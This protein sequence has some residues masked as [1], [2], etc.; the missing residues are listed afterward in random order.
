MRVSPADDIDR[1]NY[2]D[3]KKQVAK[4]EKNLKKSAKAPWLCSAPWYSWCMKFSV[5]GSSKS[6]G[7]H[8]ERTVATAL[9]RFPE[10]TAVAT[11]GAY[12]V[13]TIAIQLL[14][15]ILPNAERP[16][17]APKGK[18][19]NRGVVSLATELIEVPGGYLKRDDKLAEFGE[20]GL[21]A[22]PL[23]P[24]EEMRSG[25]W[26]TIRRAK[27]LGHVVYLFPLSGG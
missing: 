15:R 13:D 17:Y 16:L 25:T 5:T 4:A 12:G 6:F 23:T 26:A 8:V 21:I 24:Y 14:P 22:F 9:S 27:K 2:K 3:R 10:A 19:Y 18:K 7:A 11:G 20:D 1:K